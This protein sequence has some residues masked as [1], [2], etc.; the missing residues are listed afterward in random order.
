MQRPFR[1]GVNTTGIESRP[2]RLNVACPRAGR[3]ASV[4]TKLRP[5]RAITNRPGVGRS[6]S[7][8]RRSRREENRGRAST[9]S[10]RRFDVPT[11]DRPN[12]RTPRAVSPT[13]PVA[14]TPVLSQ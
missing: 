3:V 12:H 11:F 2:I 1:F 10:G 8:G 5:N 13:A 4:A 6:T 7:S 14:Q 9:P